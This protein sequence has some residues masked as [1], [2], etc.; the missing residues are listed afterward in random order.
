[1]NNQQQTI[2]KENAELKA[3]VEQLM[4]ALTTTAKR[5][6]ENRL[7]ARYYANELMKASTEQQQKT[8]EPKSTT[9]TPNGMGSGLNQRLLD[10]ANGKIES[11]S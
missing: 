4:I 11:L 10:Y 1:M 9:P 5:E 7:N 8:N 6:E 3:R 2:E